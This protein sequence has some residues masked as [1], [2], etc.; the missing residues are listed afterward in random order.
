MSDM[1]RTH[2]PQSLR[3]RYDA[4][5][6]MIDAVCQEHLTEEYAQLCR[7]MATALCRKRPSPVTRGRP[8]SWAC[9][10]VYAIGSANF[11]FDKSQTPHLTASQLCALFGVS[12]STGGNKATEIRRMFDIGP[13]DPAWCLPSLLDQNPLVWMITVNGLIVDAR[14]APRA[15]QEEAL[16]LGLIPYLPESRA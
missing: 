10:I 4:L 14:R 16:R 5:M 15:I 3:P 6:E 12:A 9:G 8:E 13:M 7:R 11:L 1:E 2:I